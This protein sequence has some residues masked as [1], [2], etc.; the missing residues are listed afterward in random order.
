MQ[1]AAEGGKRTRGGGCWGSRPE[2]SST[3]VF[4]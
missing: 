3:S 2:G 4:W 1:D